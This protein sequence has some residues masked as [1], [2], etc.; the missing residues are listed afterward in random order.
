MLRTATQQSPLMRQVLAYYV[1]CART[2]NHTVREAA[3]A[4]IAEL[5]AKLGAEAVRPHLPAI[6]RALLTCLRDDSW[7]VCMHLHCL[8][9]S[10]LPGP[11]PS[12]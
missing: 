5:A 10:R 2:N 1:R 4:C 3:C 7:P 11:P 8:C 9:P 6:L 12:G